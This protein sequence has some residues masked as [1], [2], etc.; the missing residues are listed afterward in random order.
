M[1]TSFRKNSEKGFTLIELMIVIAII[2]ILAAIAIPQFATYRI[3]ANNTS[4]ESLLKNTV[5]CEA[6]LNSDLGCWGTN[7]SNATLTGVA[8][9]TLPT[10]GIAI[11]GQRPA[12]TASVTGIY[13][14][15]T[16]NRLASSAVGI[17]I[18][19]AMGFRVGVTGNTV[20]GA[21]V[22]NQGYLILTK[23]TNGNRAFAA[24]N[25]VSDVIYYVQNEQWLGMDITASVAA[26][27]TTVGALAAQT[28]EFS[29]GINGGG[30]P[31]A[32]WTTLGN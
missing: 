23:G 29:G 3:R 28:N 17:T 21:N 19:D 32:T 27:L 6:A 31:S 13:I 5:T 4:A 25:N 8:A 1:F 15:G 7:D 11:N 14:H 18:P 9:S 20:A 16:N 10:I 30:A 22:Y 24:E 26:G 2:G 12:A